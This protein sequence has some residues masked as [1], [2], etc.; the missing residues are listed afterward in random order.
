MVFYKGGQCHPHKSRSYVV[1]TKGTALLLKIKIL[2]NIML[3]FGGC[4]PI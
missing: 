4:F 3:I 2:K 1:S